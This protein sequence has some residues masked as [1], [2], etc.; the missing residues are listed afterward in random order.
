MSEM[1]KGKV[2]HNSQ[3][4]SPLCSCQEDQGLSRLW[5]GAE[6]SSVLPLA[7]TEEEWKDGADQELS[8]W[9]NIRGRE[10]CLW[11]E[12]RVQEFYQWQEEMTVQWEVGVRVQQ[13]DTTQQELYHWEEN[14]TVQEL[15]AW[16]EDDDRYQEL[17][18]WEEDPTYQELSQWEDE[19]YQDLSLLEDMQGHPDIYQLEVDKRDPELPQIGNRNKALSQGKGYNIKELPQWKKGKNDQMLSQQ[20]EGVSSQRL[21]Q[22]GEEVSYKTWDK[23]LHTENNEDVQTCAQQRPSSSSSIG[24]VTACELPRT[25]P[26]LGSPIEAE[27]AAIAALAGAA[28]EEKPSRPLAPKEEEAPES[29]ILSDEMPFSGT[30]SQVP[31]PCSPPGCSQALLDLEGHISSEVVGKAALEVQES[32]QQPEEERDLEQSTAAKLE[33]AAPAEKEDRLI[34]APH[35]PCCPPSP[36]PRLLGGQA[37]SEQQEEA[38]RRSVLSEQ[39][40][41]ESTL[42][43]EIKLS[44]CEDKEDPELSQREKNKFQEVSQGVSCTEQ[45]LSPGEAD[46][47]QELPQGEACMEK[48]LSPGEVG[49]YQEL[50]PGEACTEQELSPGE[51]GSY[52][53]LAQGEYCMERELSPEESRSYLEFSDWEECME[54]GFSQEVG[55]SQKLSI[56]EE[57]SEQELSHEASSYQELS[58]WE[59]PIGQEL[60]KVEDSIGQ[61]VS[62]G[63]INRPSIQSSWEN[64]NDKELMQDS[65]EHMSAHSTRVKPL[66]QEDELDNLSVLELSEEEDR[67]QRLARFAEDRLP[68]PVP[69]EAWV[70]HPAFEPYPHV[71]FCASPPYVR[72]QA[73]RGHAVSPAFKEQA[74]EVGPALCSCPRCSA[75]RLGA[76]AF[77]W[78]PAPHKKRP[79]RLR[80]ALGSLFHCPCLVPQPED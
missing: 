68:V 46:R 77:R 12:M 72:A 42:A 29:P 57:Y 9:G 23:P 8:Q 49:S 1:E 54:K 73:L 5:M 76:Q 75:P 31:A 47:C 6:G 2:N 24:T 32:G 38:D 65:W 71:P 40:S 7:E 52:Q 26:A 17:S 66:L 70:G 48:E 21:S 3:P 36:S 74:P 56:W 78:Q 22:R 59:E 16:Q 51:V 14:T 18:Q 10:L 25:S 41:E 62:K 15:Y 37:L 44:Q 67:E 27:P 19:G 63:N 28:E 60:S 11:E 30:E 58:D 69:Q 80:Q 45:E 61:K 35:S 55:S 53:E 50:S 13:G 64:D 79:S 43:G 33:A 39:E 20:G 4:P 34:S